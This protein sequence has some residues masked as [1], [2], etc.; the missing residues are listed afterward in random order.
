MVVYNDMTTECNSRPV[1]VIREALE[2]DILLGEIAS[3]TRLDEHTMAERFSVS[4]T[5]VRE[6]LNQLIATGLVERQPHRGTFVRGYD[7]IELLELFE[8]MGELESSCGRLAAKRCDAHDVTRLEALV[9]HCE[10]A[11]DDPDAYY[12]ANELLHSRLY[13]LSGN[14]F[15]ERQA[16]ELH[17]RLQGFRRLQLR[18]PHRLK[19]SMSEHRRVL[20]AIRARDGM[21]AA[22]ALRFH[23]AI[24]G[25]RFRDLVSRL[26]L[27]P[28]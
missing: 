8:L 26:P 23:V 1:D 25:E 13:A 28:G 12:R 7:A 22:Q 15:L 21:A 20:D 10:R 11:A 3:G 4:R 17:R 24:Q 6:A 19:D 5:P 18:L 9:E 16:A 2:Q 27:E 14:R